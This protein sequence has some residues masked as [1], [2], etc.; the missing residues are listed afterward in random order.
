MIGAWIFFFVQSNSFWKCKHTLWFIK[1]FYKE[2]FPQ[3]VNFFPKVKKQTSDFSKKKERTTIRTNF[4]RNER[5]VKDFNFLKEHNTTS[6]CIVS[7]M[8]IA[9][10]FDNYLWIG[11]NVK[12][13]SSSKFESFSIFTYLFEIEEQNQG[14]TV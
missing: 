11:K 5:L 1:N 2:Q 13:S 10:F 9:K 12:R 7:N 6:T 14:M 3:L 4:S 8:D